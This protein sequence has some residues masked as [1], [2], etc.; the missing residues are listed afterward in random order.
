MY[1]S[2]IQQSLST[3]FGMLVVAIVIVEPVAKYKEI[4][5]SQQKTLL[6]ALPWVSKLTSAVNV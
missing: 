1:S 2:V 3:C 6:M 5:F 4:Q